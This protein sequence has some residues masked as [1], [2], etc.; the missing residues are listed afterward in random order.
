M[1]YTRSGI[2]LRV[3]AVKTIVIF[4]SKLGS[5]RRVAEYI[6]GKIGS[7]F[8]DLK[9]NPAPDV[10]GFDRIILGTGVYVGS[11]SKRMIAFIKNADLSGKD[12]RMFVCCM[13]KG[14]NGDEQLRQI[15]DK[16][17]FPVVSFYGKNKEPPSVT[18]DEF[19]ASL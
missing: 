9:K 15:N 4:A 16:Y 5:T 3:N 8:I 1:F 7:E 18:I 10:S 13:L 19:V 2:A 14:E 6:A 12:V 17:G 11:I